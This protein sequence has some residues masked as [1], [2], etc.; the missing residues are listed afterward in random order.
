MF[1]SKGGMPQ[2]L[3]PDVDPTLRKKREGWGPLFRGANNNA[4]HKPVA[5]P[6]DS[7]EKSSLRERGRGEHLAPLPEPSAKLFHLQLPFGS[8]R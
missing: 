6:L 5:P 1:L 8:D 7:G 4:R 2:T 3:T